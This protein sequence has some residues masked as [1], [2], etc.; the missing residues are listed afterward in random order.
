MLFQ[1]VHHRVK[2]NLTTVLSLLQLQ[3]MPARSKQELSARIRAM[4]AL[5]EQIY[6]SDQFGTIDLSGYVRRIAENLRQTM[7]EGV[8]LVCQLSQIEVDADMALPLGL[9]VNE[10]VT[11]A[12]KH[13]FPEGRGGTV[14]VILERPEADRARLCIR[15]DG[16]GFEGEWQAS[17]MGSRLIGGLCRQITADCAFSSDA[18][19][20][21]TVEFPLLTSRDDEAPRE[22]SAGTSMQIATAG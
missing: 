5:H 20:V 12:F 16:I 3:P 9:I 21:V 6:L 4:A 17:G 22:P 1:E 19:T 15:D 18:G 8:H 14:T 10:A 11:N 7:P 2:N 13:G